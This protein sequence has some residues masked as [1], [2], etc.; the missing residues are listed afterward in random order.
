MLFVINL[1]VYMVYVKTYVVDVIRNI[2]L[3]LRLAYLAC[4]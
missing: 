2:D 4:D 3:T 1:L